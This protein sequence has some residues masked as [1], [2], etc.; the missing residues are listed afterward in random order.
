MVAAGGFIGDARDVLSLSDTSIC[1]RSL[2][3][4]FRA[5]F[6]E[7][8]RDDIVTARNVGENLF[9]GVMGLHRVGPHLPEMVVRIADWQFR[10]ERIFLHLLKPA[11][12]VGM[13]H[14]VPPLYAPVV[15]GLCPP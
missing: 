8:G 7:N 11:L 10:L 5:A 14:H 4:K 15:F 6:D 2:F 12:I 9:Q 1:F 13:L 3:A